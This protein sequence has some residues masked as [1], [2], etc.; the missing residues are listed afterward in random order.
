MAGRHPRSS[1]H[2]GQDRRCITASSSRRG[3]TSSLSDED[4]LITPCP[5][6][7]QENRRMDAAR[8]DTSPPQEPRS[9]AQRPKSWRDE[10]WHFNPLDCEGDDIDTSALW[11]TMLDIERAFGCYKSARMRAALELGD[12]EVPVRK[13]L[14][15]FSSRCVNYKPTDTRGTQASK[16]CLDLLNDS[17]TQL[18]EESRRQLVDFLHSESSE[19]RRRST[20][21]W[22]RRVSR[23]PL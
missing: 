12:K 17:I 16:T 5:L 3:S 1:C 14:V 19:P 15:P 21:S 2:S 20:S 8:L 11:R 6:E 10:N 4:D 13:L 9:Q 18:P 7:R 23:S 22:K